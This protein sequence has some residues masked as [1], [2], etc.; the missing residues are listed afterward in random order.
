MKSLT[1]FFLLFIISCCAHAQVD[2][3]EIVWGENIKSKK[4]IIT[5]ILSIE[6]QDE[7][8]AI[9][10]S[11]K[12]FNRETYLEKYQDL[13][14]VEQVEL[15]QEFVSGEMLMQDILELNNHLYALNY[16]R[17][18]IDKSLKAQALITDDL[19]LSSEETT[20]YN[21]KFTRGRK[22]TI[23]EYERAISRNEQRLAFVIG[24][25]GEIESNEVMT[26]KVFDDQLQELWKQK[27]TIP[28]EKGL[29]NIESSIISNEG[30]V[31]I[32][33]TIY[34]DKK[35]RVRQERNYENFV[36]VVD[37]S[38]IIAQHQLALKDKF[39]RELK[40]SASSEGD[41]LCGGFYSNEGFTAD[42]TFYMTIDANTFKIKNQSMMAFS[43]DFL[44]QGMSSRAK[45]KTKKKAQRGRNIGLA[46]IDFRDIIVKEDGGALL[47]GE[48][49]N[50]Y[51]T[52]TTDANGNTS[53][54][55]HYNYDDIYVI[56]I[57]ADGKI[58]WA[59]KIPKF[60]HTT[61]DGGFYSSFFMVIHKDKI[62]FIFN[63]RERKMYSLKVVSLNSKGEKT[64]GNLV[65]NSKKEN[66]KIRPK[67]CEQIS[68]H[69]FILFSVSKKYN[70]LAKVT[71]N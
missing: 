50:I 23:G 71:I 35:D 47:V 4:T 16:R 26:I 59:K 62:N 24:H 25:P 64:D 21:I 40:L 22:N 5:D 3:M 51:T 69:E 56:N 41:L 6:N 39:I 15:T 2:Q 46:H 68:D 65:S 12:L 36:L 11:M 70:K 60:Q 58:E 66:L 67:S 20:L 32:L 43:I 31:Y 48:H 57:S 29:T 8:Y 55:T 54:T 33:T 19:S 44:T 7:I 53:T 10:Q 34:K 63:E 30:I 13:Q 14:L 28:Y 52:T 61:N 1:C 9:K 38:G 45:A 37:S 49:I 42:G 27:I 18:K 17:S